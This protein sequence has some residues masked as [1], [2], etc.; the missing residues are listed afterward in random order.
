MGRSSTEIPNTSA[1]RQIQL[2]QSRPSTTGSGTQLYALYVVDVTQGAIIRQ[3]GW[4]VPP[5]SLKLSEPMAAEVVATQ[6]GGF[7][8]D[9][10][11][12]YFKDATITGTFGFRPT[13]KTPGPED[14]LGIG[15]S[16]AQI[17]AAGAALGSRDGNQ[18]KDFPKGEVTGHERLV[19]LSNLLRFYGDRKKSR[20]TAADTVMVYANFKMGE[21]YV[22]MPTG[23]NRSRT[24]PGDRFKTQYDLSLKYLTPLNVMALPQDFLPNPNR[25]SGLQEQL[26]RIKKLVAVLEAVNQS[27]ERVGT[28]ALD[29]ATSTLRT[30]FE[31]VAQL[32]KTASVLVTVGG[33]AISNLNSIL[34][35]PLEQM[36]SVY[37]ESI[38]VS[39]I[40]DQARTF[41]NL[42]N[43]YRRMARQIASVYVGLKNTSERGD[44][45]ESARAVGDLFR[46]RD[47]V[48]TLDPQGILT[49]RPMQ[50]DRGSGTSI[51]ARPIP[52]GYQVITVPH[53]MTLK[54]MAAKF[55]GQAGRWKEIVHLNRLRAPYINPSGDGF[56]VLRPGDPIKIP[57]VPE[58]GT[59]ENNVFSAQDS[60]QNQ[61]ARRYGRDL[62]IDPNT[63]DFVVDSQGDLATIEGLDNLRQAMQ[64]KVFTRPGDLKAHP[65]FGLGMERAV[66][67]GIAV[68]QLAGYHLSVHSTLLSD[69]RIERLK[70]LAL[71]V[72]GD[73][74]QI[75]AVIIPKD[76]DDSLGLDLRTRRG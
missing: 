52:A 30:I 1:Q 68:D 37:R 40:I 10:R 51:G 39:Q 6:E 32:V 66:G 13:P 62:R 43:D 38:R 14:F 34:R 53:R 26:G 5:Q 46:P 16:V 59:D 49:T 33:R 23:F 69:T 21:V 56:T 48:A 35:F 28:N 29:T 64:I 75:K 71:R 11:G 41:G 50:G 19:A 63:H 22:V 76:R 12:Q 55:L 70:S 2:A 44:V 74:L 25:P 20:D 31:P 8:T 60:I 15:R 3:F 17:S 65:W 72:S 73:I 57:A 24:A 9:E 7:F 42:G 47:E 18:F 67:K 36:E 27:I 61:D 58:S 4:D 45:N 54:Q